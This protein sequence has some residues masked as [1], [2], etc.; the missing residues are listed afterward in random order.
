LSATPLAT[1]LA[2]QYIGINA[3]I[4]VNLATDERDGDPQLSLREA[5]ENAT[6]APGPD[7]IVFDPAVFPAGTVVT[8]SNTLGEL[9]PISSDL[10]IDA[11]GASVTLAVTSA[12]QSPTG[13]YGLRIVGGSVAV[14]GL[15]FRNFAFNYL[16]EM[17]TP[18]GNNCGASGAQLE[19]G[20]IRIDGGT[21]VLDSNRFEDPAVA[22]RNC[23]AASVRIHG[24]TRHRIVGN[25]WTQQ[26]MDSVFVA[27]SVVEIADNVMITPT[28][29]D[30]DDE[31]VYISSQGGADLWIVGNLIVDNEYSGVRAGG[32]DAG[33]LYIVNNTFVRNGRTSLSALRRDAATRP[34]ILRNNLY[35]ANNPTAILA[36]NNGVGFDIAYEAVV[37]SP[38][39][40]GC[41]SAMIDMP[42]IAMP[43]NAGVE[44]QAGTTREDF[45]PSVGSPL[46]DTATPW[47]DRNG[48]APRRY[49]GTGQERGAI[50]TSHSAV[51]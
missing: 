3:P 49:S 18:T 21:V 25:T 16:D 36:D 11:T 31:G 32:T 40:T 41:G 50:E 1:P 26:V 38:L 27:A 44:N 28:N 30:R 19:G 45:T 14:A 35:V 7:R 2:L 37:G 24:G 42:T 5:L 46:V 23:Y 17:I 39:C 51:P 20:A 12:W 9:P 13:R 10:V 48:T 43:A 15:T 29:P 47:L 4:V 22:E 34:M 6:N 8:L 33:K